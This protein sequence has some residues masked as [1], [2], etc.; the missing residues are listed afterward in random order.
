[1]EFDYKKKSM[2]LIIQQAT[3]TDLE[4]IKKLLDNNN[5]PTT[6]IQQ[7]NIQFFIGLMDDK[8]MSVIGLEKYKNVALLRSLAVTD[9]FKKQQVGTRLIQQIFN[10]CATEHIDKLYLFTTT[11]EKYFL[12]FGFLKIER[13]EAPDILKQTREFKDICPASAV[14]M[15]K[16]LNQG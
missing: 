16:K 15:F 14:L 9:L 13:I 11:A 5:L 2:N 10:L 4:A 1:L 6:D 7:D 8:I 3:D 12:K